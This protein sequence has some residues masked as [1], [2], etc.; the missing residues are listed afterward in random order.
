MWTG[1]PA[2]SEQANVKR[3]AHVVTSRALIQQ[4]MCGSPA[5]AVNNAWLPGVASR[6]DTRVLEAV[7]RLAHFVFE[8]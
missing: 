8:P 3:Q 1:L 2:L 7:R 5:Q 4:L 6:V